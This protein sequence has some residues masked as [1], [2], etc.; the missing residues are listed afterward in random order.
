MSISKY[1]GLPQD[2]QGAPLYW[3]E[4]DTIPFRGLPPNMLKGDEIEQIPRVYDAK[5]EVLVLP[6]DIVRYQEIVDHCA[7]GAWCLRHEK[8]EYDASNKTYTVFMC[9][10]EMY[11]QAPSNK[12]AME[13]MRDDYRNEQLG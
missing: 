5:A 4:A 12:S 1:F 11:R 3:N 2:P 7:N 8:F 9:W 13:R 10:L 6:Q